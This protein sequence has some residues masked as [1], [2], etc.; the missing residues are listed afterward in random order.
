MLKIIEGL[1]ITLNQNSLLFLPLNRTDAVDIFK[2]ICHYLLQRKVLLKSILSE[3][4]SFLV[5][6]GFLMFSVAVMTFLV[7]N[8]FII[9]NPFEDNSS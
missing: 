8:S 4:F 7:S 9:Q 6:Y 1:D 5:L 3:G 2:I